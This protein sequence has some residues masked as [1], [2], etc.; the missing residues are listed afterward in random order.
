MSAASEGAAGREHHSGG[1]RLIPWLD[2]VSRTVHH[3]SLSVHFV[4]DD[5]QQSN[6]YSSSFSYFSLA[7]AAAAAATFIIIVAAAVEG[8]NNKTSSRMKLLS[9]YCAEMHC[10]VAIRHQT[11]A[12]AARGVEFF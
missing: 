4:Q 10:V 2:P 7:A 9:I 3:R 12:A 1:F 5:D 6:T 8:S 11:A